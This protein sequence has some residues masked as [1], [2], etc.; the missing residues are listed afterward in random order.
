MELIIMTGKPCPQRFIKAYACG[1]TYTMLLAIMAATSILAGVT[2]SITSS[3]IQRDLERE[4]IFRGLQYQQAIESFYNA[5]V[6]R[7]YPRSLEDLIKDPRFIYKV[8]LKRLYQDP[9][10]EKDN[11][12]WQVL[13]NEE[14][15][16]IGVASRSSKSAF[17]SSG[18]PRGVT[19]VDG[20]STYQSWQFTYIPEN[21]S[22]LLQIP[23][24]I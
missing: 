19:Q 14:G 23:M 11:N 16:I 18:F 4:L 2:A 9:F 10:G 13:K 17:K 22:M 12:D 3:Y 7:T 8:H 5:A 21:P 15:G 24:S 1:F 6:P 20:N